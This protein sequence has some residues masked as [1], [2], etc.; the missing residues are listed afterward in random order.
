MSGT[1]TYTY[2]RFYTLYIFTHLR[3]DQF[4]F[5]FRLK[6][7]YLMR[8]NHDFRI[9]N[10]I[11]VFFF[12]TSSFPFFQFGRPFQTVASLFSLLCC[13]CVFSL[14]LVLLL[15]SRLKPSRNAFILSFC[16]AFVLSKPF[17]ICSFHLCHQHSTG[18]FFI[19]LHQIIQPTSETNNS[20][21][22]QLVV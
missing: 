11:C 8:V 9:I 14:L 1:H 3:L 13:A 6:M 18:I 5:H 7:K 17:L 22:L 20:L 2:A 21:S 16:L 4:F 19:P 15:R 10:F 12:S